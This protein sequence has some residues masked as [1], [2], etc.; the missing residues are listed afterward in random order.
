[1]TPDTHLL[2]ADDVLSAYDA[3]ADLYPHIPSMSAWRAWELAAYR[4]FRLDGPVLDV[5]CGDGRYFRLVWPDAA[6]VTGID[7]DPPT[8]DA[9]RASGVYRAVHLAPAH[10]P[11]VPAAS[12]ASAFANC[13]LEHMDELPA[14]LRAVHDALRPGG[15]FLFS[16]VTDQFVAWSLVPLLLRKLGLDDP[17]AALQRQHEHYHHLVNPFPPQRWADELRRAGFGQIV[18][19]P[20]VPELTGRLV[21]L[22]DQLWHVPQPDGS[23]LGLQLHG[24]FTRLPGFVGGYRDVLAGLMRME[25]RPDVGSGAVF[26]A[27]RPA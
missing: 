9:A 21:V 1:M 17:A 14:V 6:D 25:P 8:V 10:R 22:L 13:A 26:A 20:I 11:P 15:T 18:H 23:E 24:Y 27:R 4:R 7:I 12:F 16:V 19:V 3:V 2:S 5:G